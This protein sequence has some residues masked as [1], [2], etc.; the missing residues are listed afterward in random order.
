MGNSPCEYCGAALPF[1]V[2]KPTRRIRSHHFQNC[3][4]RPQHKEVEPPRRECSC[5]ASPLQTEISL[6][7]ELGEKVHRLLLRAQGEKES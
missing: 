2:D 5:E 1:G 7:K 4:M 3:S 6:L